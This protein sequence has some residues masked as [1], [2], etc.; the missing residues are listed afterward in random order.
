MVADRSEVL[1]IRVKPANSIRILRQT[2]NSV[3]TAMTSV[4]P[5]PRMPASIAKNPNGSN[6]A[7]VIKLSWPN[8]PSPRNAFRPK[9][10]A[11]KRLMKGTTA[12]TRIL[13]NPLNPC[14][15]PH[16]GKSRYTPNTMQSANSV[17]KIMPTP[18]ARAGP[19][20]SNATAKPATGLDA[21]ILNAC[22]ASVEAALTLSAANAVGLGA[23]IDAPQ[24]E[25]AT[26]LF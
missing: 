10:L 11:P 24:L 1:Q 16:S 9:T 8:P 18:S 6:D 17:P 23:A 14:G 19:R 25:Q 5:R 4:F 21:N 26:E 3:N 2:A 12:T 13:R 7:P 22:K 20:L 15:L